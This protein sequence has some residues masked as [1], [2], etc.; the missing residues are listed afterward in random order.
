[1]C[2]WKSS[3]IKMGVML[4]R[5]EGSQE[6]KIITP[7]KCRLYYYCSSMARLREQW[8]AAT[9]RQFITQRS[10]EKRAC[11]GTQGHM[12]KLKEVKGWG[13]H[14]QV[15]YCGFYGKNRQGRVSRFSIG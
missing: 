14:G 6:A 2:I 11:Y 4:M 12:G 15:L 10:Q 9:N 3:R 5:E 8:T 1:M 13:K 7:L